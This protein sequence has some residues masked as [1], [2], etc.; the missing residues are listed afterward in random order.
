MKNLLIIAL[1]FIGFSI[2]AQTV[3]TETLAVKGN[4]E[5]CKERIEN[6][7][8]I[9]GVKVCKWN[10]K[11]KVATITY[12]TLKVSMDQISAAIAK[13]GHDAGNTKADLKDYKKLPKCCQYNDGKC[14]K[15]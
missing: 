1:C 3:K 12:D 4:C 9:K 2:K 14:E 7:A 6:A 15:K 13:S 8:D 5:Q 11:T 10:E